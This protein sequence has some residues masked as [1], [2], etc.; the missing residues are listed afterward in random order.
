VVVLLQVKNIVRLIKYVQR[1]KLC[2][3]ELGNVIDAQIG[4]SFNIKAVYPPRKGSYLLKQRNAALVAAD[5]VFRPVIACVHGYREAQ[6]APIFLPF[7]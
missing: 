1:S 5:G 6:F 3:D 2:A 7:A 4:Y